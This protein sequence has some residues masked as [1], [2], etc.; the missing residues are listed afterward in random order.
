MYLDYATG[1]LISKM[2]LGANFKQ[3]EIWINRSKKVLANGSLT[4]LKYY[5]SFQKTFFKITHDFV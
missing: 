5:Y 1:F 3:K 4:K 2:S